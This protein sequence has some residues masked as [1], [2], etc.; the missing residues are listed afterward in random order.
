MQPFSPP[1]RPK[2]YEYTG[3]SASVEYK[4]GRCSA[5]IEGKVC[6]TCEG[7]SCNR[8]KE[9]GTDFKCKNWEFKSGKWSVAATSSTCKRLKD[10]KITCK[11]L[12]YFSRHFL[13]FK[14]SK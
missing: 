8:P 3:L 2:F 14:M 6:E 11:M 7:D 13:A 9:T 10:T 4:C 5:A 12:V 1:F